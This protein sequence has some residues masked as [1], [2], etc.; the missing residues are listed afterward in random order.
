[1]SVD[2]HPS[3]NGNL[4]APQPIAPE[5][6]EDLATANLPWDG[7]WSIQSP[8]DDKPGLYRVHQLDAR[9][10][11]RHGAGRL[12]NAEASFLQVVAY[13]WRNLSGLQAHW[14]RKL[15][16]QHGSLAA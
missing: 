13:Q 9:D 6:I 15:E 2:G 8:A 3:N 1:M 11:L 14:L 5:T 12:T 10:L 7:R 4:A 16:R